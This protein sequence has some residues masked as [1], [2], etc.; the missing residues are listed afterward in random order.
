MAEWAGKTIRQL[1]IEKDRHRISIAR[2]PLQSS[3]NYTDK[4][5]GVTARKNQQRS[6]QF[7]QCC[8]VG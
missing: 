6:T 8:F 7:G 5:G 2:N 1:C 4:S 3:I